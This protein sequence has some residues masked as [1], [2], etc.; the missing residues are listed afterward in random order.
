MPINRFLTVDDPA[1]AS[2]STHMLDEHNK[3]SNTQ[4]L[5]KH[6]VDGRNPSISSIHLGCI[7]PCKYWD[8]NYQPQLVSLPDFLHWVSGK[9]SR[10]HMK[11]PRMRAKKLKGPSNP[12]QGSSCGIFSI[13]PN[14]LE[15]I[16]RLL[17]D[18]FQEPIP[19]RQI[20]FVFASTSWRPSCFVWT[21]VF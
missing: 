10:W 1:G 12:Y 19:S 6:T 14:D 13:C 11:S 5:G 2:E 15:A 8:F 20:C 21:C 4:N 16:L 18:F 7:E 9:G 3:H 17:Q